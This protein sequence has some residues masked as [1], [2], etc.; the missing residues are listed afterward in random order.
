MVFGCIGLF[1]VLTL[2]ALVIAAHIVVN[3]FQSISYCTKCSLGVIGSVWAYF[4]L[5]AI[6]TYGKSENQETVISALIC[7]FPCLINIVTGIFSYNL[8]YI[9]FTEEQP[10]V[11]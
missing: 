5:E 9:I 2:E 1:G 7:S 11:N 8:A 10:T 3:Y 4:L 6:L